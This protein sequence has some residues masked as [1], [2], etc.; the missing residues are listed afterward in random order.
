MGIGDI[1]Q[2]LSPPLRGQKRESILRLF[3]EQHAPEESSRVRLLL[4]PAGFRST[5][6]FTDDQLTFYFDFFLL[7][8]SLGDLLQQ[9]FGCNSSHF[10]HGH[11]YRRDSGP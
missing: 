9:E 7:L 4:S 8:S 2:S 3:I 1:S 6:C 10:D 5:T 11:V